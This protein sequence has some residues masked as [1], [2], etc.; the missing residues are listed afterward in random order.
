MPTVSTDSQGGNLKKLGILGA[1]ALLALAL[2]LAASAQIT[3]SATVVVRLHVRLGHRH[4]QRRG[5]RRRL[6]RDQHVEHGE[7]DLQQG[8]DRDRRPEQRGQRQR[9]A[10]APA[11][12]RRRRTT[13]T[14]TCRGP[15]PWSTADRTPARRCPEP[16]GTRRTR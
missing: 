16:S 13:S 4:P 15:T 5:D 1:G 10:E 12:R 9:D 6:R 7:P 2:P 14:T 3:I 11:R 8:R